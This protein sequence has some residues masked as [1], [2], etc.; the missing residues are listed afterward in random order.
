[1]TRGVSFGCL[2]ITGDLR[3]A[4]SVES[5]DASHS[6]KL[7]LSMLCTISGCR[8]IDAHRYTARACT[9]LVWPQGA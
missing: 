9:M 4:G 8:K 7:T 2:P 6:H 5:I 3:E 1:M